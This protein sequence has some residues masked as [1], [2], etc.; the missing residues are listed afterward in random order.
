[1]TNGLG[2]GRVAEYGRDGKLRWEITGLKSP[3]DAQVLANGNVFVFEYTG[4]RLTERTLKGEVVWDKTVPGTDMIYD[5][6]RLANGNTFVTTRTGL[7]EIDKDGKEVASR[8]VGTTLSAARK[9]RTG[10]IAYL[11]VAGKCVRLDKDGN[12][13]ASFDVGRVSMLG[14]GMELLPNGHV[15]LAL[16]AQGKVAEFDAK[17]KEVWS[18]SVDRPSSVVRLPNG[19]ALVCSTVGQCVVELDRDGKEVWKMALTERPYRA[20]RR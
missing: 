9:S 19:H 1:M 17:G 13:A 5:A 2:A 12:E 16:Y 6:Q 18:A 8:A 11:T 3:R 20:S 15:V 10:E 4:R 7:V 14:G